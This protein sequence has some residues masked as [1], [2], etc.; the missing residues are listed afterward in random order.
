[1]SKTESKLADCLSPEEKS[2]QLMEIYRSQIYLIC[3]IS[4][5]QAI[6]QRHFILVIS[7]LIVAFYKVLENIDNLEAILLNMDGIKIEHLSYLFFA[8]SIMGIFISLGWYLSV[9]YYTYLVSCKHE[10]MKKLERKLAYHFFEREWSHITEDKKFKIYESLSTHKFLIPAIFYV[11]FVF[12]LP[13]SEIYFNGIS[14]I[15]KLIMLIIV[16]TAF[17]VCIRLVLFQRSRL[18]EVKQDLDSETNKGEEK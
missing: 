13:L 5:R 6:M 18:S 8:F 9:D 12:L 1:M 16:P 2:S 11:F 15:F 7:A 17:F 3:S 10:E 14:N 4:D